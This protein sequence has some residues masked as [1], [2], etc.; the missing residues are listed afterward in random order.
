MLHCCHNP[1]IIKTTYH[2][3]AWKRVSSVRVRNSLRCG[4]GPESLMGNCAWPSSISVLAQNLASACADALLHSNLLRNLNPDDS[5]KGP[6]LE[7]KSRH[8]N[9]FQNQVHL[10]GLY[11]A[12]TMLHLHVS[13]CRMWLWQLGIEACGHEILGPKFYSFQARLK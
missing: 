5:K 12:L 9:M 6:G 3:H 2:K 1:R 10:S 4:P 13:V 8:G 11:N 7:S